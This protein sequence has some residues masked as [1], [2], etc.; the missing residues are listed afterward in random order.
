MLGRLGDRV[1][2]GGARSAEDHH[3]ARLLVHHVEKGF[4]ADRGAAL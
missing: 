3:F 4:H 1:G 2:D